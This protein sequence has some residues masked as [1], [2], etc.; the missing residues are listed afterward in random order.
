MAHGIHNLSSS[1]V[2]E[3]VKAADTPVVV[4]FWA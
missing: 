4:D 3:A 1:T 2:D